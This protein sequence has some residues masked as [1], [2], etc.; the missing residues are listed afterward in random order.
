[1]HAKQRMHF[2]NER[3]F[4]VQG[5]VCLESTFIPWFTQSWAP[6]LLTGSIGYSHFCNAFRYRMQEHSLWT[7]SLARS[8]HLS[9]WYS[10]IYS[11]LLLLPP[12]RLWPKIVLDLSFKIASSRYCFL[13]TCL[14]FALE[15]KRDE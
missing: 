2:W 3:V 13:A 11:S 8:F 15:R 6:D 12:P 10:A 9:L 14:M 1:M 5:V 4:R 7:A